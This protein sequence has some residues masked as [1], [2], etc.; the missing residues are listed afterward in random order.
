VEPQRGVTSL[1]AAGTAF[2]TVGTAFHI[3]NSTAAERR[4]HLFQ[5][6][7]LGGDAELQRD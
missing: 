4:R 7:A 6:L 3:G 2:R 5:R 1:C